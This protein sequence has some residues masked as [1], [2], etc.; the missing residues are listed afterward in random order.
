MIK[1]K[2]KY[3]YEEIHQ[4]NLNGETIH[5]ISKNTGIP[6]MS[7]YTH[8]QKNNWEYNK[9]IPIRQEGY[10]VDD[11][12]L[13]NIDSE[14]KAYFLGWMLS[15]GGVKENRLKLKLEQSD[16]YIIKEMF[17]KFSRGYK[18]TTDKNSKAMQISSTKMIL[19]LKELGCVEN[20]TKICF[21]LPNIN[22]N[23]FRHF[24]RGYFDGD[25]SLGFRSARPNQMQINICSID[26]NF[27]IQL[28]EKLSDHGIIS[29]VYL[30]K[31]KNKSLKR[32]DGEYSCDNV[33]MFRLT[34]LS[35]KDKLKF[36]EFLYNDCNIKLLRK[37]DKYK[38]YFLNT[39]STLIKKNSNIVQYIN[40]VPVIKYEL[41]DKNIFTTFNE[42]DTELILSMYK[43]GKSEFAIHK[44]T[45]VGRCAVKKII[46]LNL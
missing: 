12:Y 8:F 39:I 38:T 14:D 1:R 5:N 26:N 16:E 36:F 30:E 24:V 9:N 21:K 20:K 11:N 23:L 7:I 2:L 13:D 6:I 15:D 45:K 4:R 37:Y 10:Y 32:P 42:V 25:G 22:T 19:A 3:D 31:R 18:L 40:D 29:S 43:E 41:I 28:Q 35:H 46:S 17:N 34:L 27:L 33:D 44:E